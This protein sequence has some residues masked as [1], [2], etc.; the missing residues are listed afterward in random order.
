V[1]DHELWKRARAA[2]EK[3]ACRRETPVTVVLDDGTLAEGVIDLA[4]E[5]D[6][7]WTVIDYKSDRAFDEAG[8]DRYRQQVALYASAIAKATGQPVVPVLVRI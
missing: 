5:Q 1:L 7:T 6:G 4:F 2:D 8:E 3:G